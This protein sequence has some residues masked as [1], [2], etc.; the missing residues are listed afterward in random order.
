MEIPF[1]DAVVNRLVRRSAPPEFA[2]EA[3]DLVDE[4]DETALE[5]AAAPPTAEP[6]QPAAAKG[7]FSDG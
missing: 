2:E 4:V 5:V 6:T 1:T 7:D 3:V